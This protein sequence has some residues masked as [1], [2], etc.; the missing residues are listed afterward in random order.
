VQGCGQTRT[1]EIERRE[2][3]QPNKTLFVVNFEPHSTFMD[4]L[5]AFF[6]QWGDLERVQL[7]AKFAFVEVC[8]WQHGCRHVCC[9]TDGSVCTPDAGG[10]AMILA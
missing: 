4:D 6:E 5:R 3:A 8:T 2:T 7:K 1:R 9:M 10:I